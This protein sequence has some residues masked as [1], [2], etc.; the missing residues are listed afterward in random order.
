MKKFLLPFFYLS[1]L[2][3]FFYSLVGCSSFQSRTPQSDES[4]YRVHLET[5]TYHSGVPLVGDVNLRIGYAEARNSAFK[6]CVMYLQGLG[7]SVMNHEPFFRAITN[8]GYRVIFFDYMGQGGSEGTMNHTRVADATFR[9]LE[10]SSIANEI[11]ARFAGVNFGHSEHDCSAGKKILIGWS[12]GGLASYR[13]A[14]H[15]RAD[16]VVLIAPGIHT[17]TLVGEAAEKPHLLPIAS[18]IITER[19]LTRNAFSGLSNPHV[20]PVKPDS[21]V[22]VPLFAANLVATSKL[23]Q[24]WSIPERVHGLVFLSGDEDT[25][26]DRT[27]TLKTLARKARHF[28]VVSYDGAL[29]EIDNETEDVTTDMYSRTLR[30]LDSVNGL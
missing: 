25:Y 15:N 30:F 16:G 24:H 20:D 11:W 22:K 13:E 17:K 8:H 27:A 1:L 10:I 23:A 6:G 9:R 28:Q 14:R 19:T 26:V 21:P 12:T 18:T 2:F 5:Y 3:S 4:P 29:H 7:D